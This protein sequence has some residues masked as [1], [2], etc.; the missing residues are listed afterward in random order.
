MRFYMFEIRIF[1]KLEPCNPKKMLSAKTKNIGF[2]FLL[3]I[4]LG[5]KNSVNKRLVSEEELLKIDIDTSN[6]IFRYKA[7][8]FTLPSP[9]QATLLIKRN[10]VDLNIELINSEK[11][12]SKYNT[13]FKKAI[14]LGVFGTDLGYLNLYKKNQEALN[15][16]ITIQKLAKDLEI[17][18]SLNDSMLKRIER[19]MGNNDS[20]LRI[21][22]HIY[23][24]MDTYLTVNNRDAVGVLIIA[25]SF[26]ESMYLLTQIYTENSLNEL[27]VHLGKQKYPL[28][29]LIKLLA[30][31]YE[32]NSDFQDLIDMLTDLAYEYDCL[33]VNYSYS[34]PTVFPDIKLTMVNSDAELIL[35]DYNIFKIAEK[36]SQIRNKIISQ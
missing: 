31:Y 29:K 30:P 33:D 15:Y 21:I 17:S 27:L 24:D 23:R 13:T 22:S 20:I 32:Q 10:N 12:I 2:L 4:I 26:I 28:E 6:V 16:F 1:F 11:N 5:C 3:I 36:V 18:N 9:H 35:N 8:V 7:T 25:G 34:K 14:N 19:N